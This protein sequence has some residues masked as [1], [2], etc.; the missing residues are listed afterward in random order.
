MIYSNL[1][2]KIQSKLPKRKFWN[3]KNKYGCRLI[4]PDF[5][6]FVILIYCSG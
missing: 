6:L 1:R 2:N 4:A 3:Y 5:L